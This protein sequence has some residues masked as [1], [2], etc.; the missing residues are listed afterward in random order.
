[1][2]QTTVSCGRTRLGDNRYYRELL[3]PRGFIDAAAIALVSDASGFG[4][5]AFNRQ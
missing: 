4:N 1:L 5:V 3:E 2:G